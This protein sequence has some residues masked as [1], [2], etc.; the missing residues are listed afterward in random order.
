L[1]TVFR[2]GHASHPNWQTA[3]GLALGDA[4]SQLQSASYEQQANLGIV[5]ASHHYAL[6][7]DQMIETLRLKTGVRDWVGA[8]GHGVCATGIG[9]GDQAS[10]ALMLTHLPWNS[11]QIFAE[12]EEADVERH[13]PMEGFQAHCALIH[14][15]PSHPHLQ[16]RLQELALDTNTGLL[17]G[18]IVHG[19]PGGF[20]HLA[21]ESLTAGLSGAAFSPRVGIR[22]RVSQGCT[23]LSREHVISE[24]S[25]HYISAL[26]GKPALDVLL[27]DLELPASV[28]ASRDGD[29]ILRALPSSRLRDGLFVGLSAGERKQGRGFGDYLVRNLIGIDPKNRIV[30][31]AASPDVGD[32]V[33]FCTRDANAARQDLIRVCT[34]LREEVEEEGLQI[35]G[36]LYHSCVARGANLF[37]D[38]NVEPSLI[39][40]NLGDV[41]LIGFQANGEIFH[42]RIYSHSA[43]LTIFV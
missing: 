25:T 40:H 27:D 16:E 7:V 6:E 8:I 18:G 30:A 14:A 23:V 28:R 42:D 2:Y 13:F 9:Y 43:V 12:P 3:L 20:S 5:Y 34:E 19:E 11:Y 10:V 15:D 17:F 41:P 24:C 31:V 38:G 29:E 4:Q 33:V 36:A 1:T 35:R 37:G 32:R 26:D 22:S 21:N 39:R